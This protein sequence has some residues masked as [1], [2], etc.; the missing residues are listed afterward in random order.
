MKSE[1]VKKLADDHWSYVKGLIEQHDPGA[2][3]EIIGF[4]YTTA[5]IH[6]YKHGMEDRKNGNDQG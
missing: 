2:D 4:H 1:D 3:I 6:G 5:M